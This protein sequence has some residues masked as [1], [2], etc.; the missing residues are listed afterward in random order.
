MLWFVISDVALVLAADRWELPGGAGYLWMVL[1][2]AV[3]P[4]LAC[5]VAGSVVM[6]AVRGREASAIGMA[7]VIVPVLLLIAYM[8]FTRNMPWL[9]LWGVTMRSRGL[10]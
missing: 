10:G 1:H 6:R 7:F 9:E 2:F 4:V 3:N 5:F 8:G